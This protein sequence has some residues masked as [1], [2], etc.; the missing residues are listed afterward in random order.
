GVLER[1]VENLPA[2]RPQEIE[3]ELAMGQSD[4]PAA[5]AGN[6]VAEIAV[7]A[8]ELRPR[9]SIALRFRQRCGI[10]ARRADFLAVGVLAHQAAGAAINVR[11]E[12]EE[13]IVEARMVRAAA[14]RAAAPLVDDAL[15][16]MNARRPALPRVEGID[17]MILVVVRGWQLSQ[18]HVQRGC[19]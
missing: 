10:V 15:M 19:V 11:G 4:L 13:E 17:P 6:L 9:R 18:G 3:A 14:V 1:A 7:N 2:R 12:P 5:G 8:A 16:A